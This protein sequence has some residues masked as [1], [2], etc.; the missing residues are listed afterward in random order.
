MKEVGY[1][2]INLKYIPF[3]K[4]CPLSTIYQPTLSNF[5]RIKSKSLRDQKGDP[6]KMYKN[7]LDF[8]RK[9]IAQTSEEDKFNLQNTPIKSRPFPSPPIT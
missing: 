7:S 3:N 2:H 5:H 4:K 6:N 1:I 8:R 9:G